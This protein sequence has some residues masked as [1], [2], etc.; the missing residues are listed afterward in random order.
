VRLCSERLDSGPHGATAHRA[1]R[2]RGSSIIKGA[3][4]VKAL[5]LHDRFVIALHSPDGVGEIGLCPCPAEKSA[6]EV[7]LGV[8]RDTFSSAI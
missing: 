4:E 7:A 2:C 8:R 5:S 6:R 1:L 3:Y